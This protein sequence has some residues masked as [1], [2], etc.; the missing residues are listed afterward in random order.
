VHADL[1]EAA[2]TDALTGCMNHAALHETLRREMQRSRRTGRALTVVLIDLDHFKQVNERQGHLA[3]DEVLRRVGRALRQAV[4]PY[5]FVARYGGDEFAIVSVDSEAERGEEIARRA[6][7]RLSEA[8]AELGHDKVVT[9]ATAGVAEWTPG[10]SPSELLREADRA[11]LY[12]KQQGIRGRAIPTSTVPRASAWGAPASPSTSR[13]RRPTRCP[14]ARRSRASRCAAATAS[15][16]SPTR[17]ARACR[18]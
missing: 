6:I 16:R 4:R 9:Y 3:G 8:I 13:R 18:R 10:L 15:S 2:R 11:L 1:A 7:H 12:G 17:S 5:D 14:A